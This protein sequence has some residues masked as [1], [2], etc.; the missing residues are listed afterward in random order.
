LAA[1]PAAAKIRRRSSEIGQPARRDR[2]EDRQG[3][4]HPGAVGLEA[5]DDG[6]ERPALFGGSDL[7][8]G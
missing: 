8:V 4:R 7:D 2:A 1:A 6:R 3:R 5:G